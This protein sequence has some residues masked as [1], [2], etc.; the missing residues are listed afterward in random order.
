MSEIYVHLRYMSGIRL[1]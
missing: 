1:L